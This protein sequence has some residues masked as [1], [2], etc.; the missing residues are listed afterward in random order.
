MVKKSFKS[1]K[2][3]H[4]KLDNALFLSGPKLPFKLSDSTM[5]S[6]P[7]DKGVVVIGGQMEGDYS[8][9]Q[10]PSN[11]LIELSGDTIDTLKWTVLRQKLNYPRSEH[12]AFAISPQTSAELSEKYK[13]PTKMKLT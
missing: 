13:N 3:I 5:V 2:L 11:A 12:L 7:T 4:F 9:E 8:W 1:E 10:I 6:S